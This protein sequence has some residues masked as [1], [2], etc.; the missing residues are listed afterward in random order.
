MYRSHFQFRPNRKS[1]TPWP[2]TRERLGAHCHAKPNLPQ[3]SERG[4]GNPQCRFKNPREMKLIG[5]PHFLRDLL[6]Q[7]AGVSQPFSRRV[8]LK[9]QEQLVRAFVVVFFE[10]AAKVSAAYMA[11]PADF[12]ERPQ[13]GVILRNV[14]TALLVGSKRQA[15]R[16]IERNPRRADFKSQTFGKPGT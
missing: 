14:L 6:N 10:Q 1:Q 3:S 16:S 5:K 13:A 8:H 4:R 7:H 9:A 12:Q 11:F 2:Y 15:L